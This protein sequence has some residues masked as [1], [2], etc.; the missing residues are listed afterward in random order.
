MTF[1]RSRANWRNQREE[2]QR[3]EQAYE[4]FSSHGQSPV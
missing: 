4:D 1:I 2:K 3:L